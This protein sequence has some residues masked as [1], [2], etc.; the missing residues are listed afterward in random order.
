MVK[1][2][3]AIYFFLF[4]II[5][6]NLKFFL[7]K[8]NLCEKNCQII[9]NEIDLINCLDS[10]AI[11]SNEIIENNFPKGK[12]FLLL[13]IEISSFIL[14]VWII[15]KIFIEKKINLNSFYVNNFANKLLQEKLL[16]NDY[17]KLN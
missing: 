13:T 6:F 10:C 9:N 17:I 1:N 4:A 5:F 16:S 8:K 7:M 14:I 15:N 11:N 3:K 12:F 2:F